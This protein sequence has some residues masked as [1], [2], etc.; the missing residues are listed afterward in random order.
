MYHLPSYADYN[1]Q[2]PIIYTN[3]RS[4]GKKC[5]VTSYI[6]IFHSAF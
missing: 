4:G 2:I 1:N 5:I 3:N 6:I